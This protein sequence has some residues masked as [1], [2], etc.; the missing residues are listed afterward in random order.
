M[1]LGALLVALLFLAAGCTD[2]RQRAAVR[3]VESRV[4]AKATCTKSPRVPASALAP[5]RIRPRAA[6][7]QFCHALTLGD[8]ATLHIPR[9]GATAR[10]GGV[11]RMGESRRGVG[12]PAHAES[13]VARARGTPGRRRGRSPLPPRRCRSRLSSTSRGP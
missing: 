12:T 11:T 1:K 3:A 9:L 5:D 7:P 13:P 2:V 10:A 8:G 4:G 6:G